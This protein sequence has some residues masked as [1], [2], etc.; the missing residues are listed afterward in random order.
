MSV[1]LSKGQK[2][3]LTKQSTGLRRIV[4][5]LGWDQMEQSGGGFLKSLFGSGGA[6]IDCDASAI[7]CDANGKRTKNGDLVYYGNLQHSSGSIKHMGDN[8][9]GEG[10][11]DDE[12]IVVDLQS[13][14]AVYQKIVFVVN[15]YQAA[16]RHQHFGMIRNAFIRVVD[17]DSNQELCKYNLSDNYNGMTA[18]VFGEVCR[19]NNQWLFHAIGNGTQDTT[20]QEIV[21]RY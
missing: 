17:A 15:I 14:P 4:V 18:M 10:E 19:E 20:L 16:S 9:T 6:A 2:I 13:L 3:D 1:N 21:N 7:V 5:G 11:G 12:Q 8:L